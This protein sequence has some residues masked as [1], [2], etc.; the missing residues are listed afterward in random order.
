MDT[1]K[2]A[3]ALRGQALLINRNQNEK[4][5][6]EW[7][8]IQE[9]A[10]ALIMAAKELETGEMTPE[11]ALAMVIG[12]TVMSATVENLEALPAEVLRQKISNRAQYRSGPVP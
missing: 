10:A 7:V 6:T 4:S 12:H 2:I 1:N 5:D 8:A 9:C 11:G 3:E